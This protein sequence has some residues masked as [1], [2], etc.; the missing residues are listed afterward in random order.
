MA[1]ID[2]LPGIAARQKDK[3]VPFVARSIEARTGSSYTIAVEISQ[4]FNFL[5]GANGLALDVYIDGRHFTSRIIHKDNFNGSGLSSVIE[6]RAQDGPH[7]AMPIFS[8]IRTIEE[9]D[10]ATVEK[11][12]E[13]VKKMGTIEVH[14]EFIDGAE[15]E[16]DAAELA[17]QDYASFDIAHK[18]MIKSGQAVSHGTSHKTIPSDEVIGC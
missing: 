5:S 6:S 2:Q 1:V 15:I 12:M 11:D 3:N 17:P 10:Q 4:A 13:R 7:Q 18:A 9:A 14:L 16:K 8:D